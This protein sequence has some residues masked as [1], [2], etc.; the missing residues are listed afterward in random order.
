MVASCNVWVAGEADTPLG[1]LTTWTGSL[2]CTATTVEGSCAPLKG[3][4]AIVTAAFPVG[5]LCPLIWNILLE[6][7]K[8]IP[9]AQVLVG[10]QNCAGKSVLTG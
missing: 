10:H 6:S 7:F 4:S 5:T 9:G 1:A 2:C 8:I 3:T